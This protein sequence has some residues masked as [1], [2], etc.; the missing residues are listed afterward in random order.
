MGSLLKDATRIE[1]LQVDASGLTGIEA[2][3]VEALRT[4]NKV[5]TPVRFGG[6]SDPSVNAAKGDR[7]LFVCDKWQC[8]RAVGVE[9]DGLFDLE[10]Y[11]PM[12]GAILSPRYV[13][14]ASIPALAAGRPARAIC[15]RG[16]ILLIDDPAPHSFDVSIDASD[17]RGTGT[18]DGIPVSGRKDTFV[19]TVLVSPPGRDG[20][21]LEIHRSGALVREPDGCFTSTFSLRGGVP[22]SARGLT[23]ALT[24]TYGTQLVAKGSLEVN[25]QVAPGEHS[26]DIS[27]DERGQLH[28]ASDLTTGTSYG[29]Q[30]WT[31]DQ[32]VDHAA[33]WI[34][35]KPGVSSAHQDLVVEIPEGGGL[36]LV[37]YVRNTKDPTFR[38]ALR[39]ESSYDFRMYTE[40]GFAKLVYVPEK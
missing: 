33:V 32:G 27:I 40:L 26:L 16:K 3:V 36:N 23:A 25:S 39:A 5:N 9:R 14:T 34:K 30:I 29:S 28:F 1:I 7:V 19:E 12:D 4:T 31:D 24:G 38:V 13:E 11:Q 20:T 18:V 21:G 22:R 8:P 17:A 6:F 15:L 37:R 10:A 2:H 35:L